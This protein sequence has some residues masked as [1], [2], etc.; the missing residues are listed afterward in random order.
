MTRIDISKV[1]PSVLSALR[2]RSQTDQTIS[3]LSPEE[4]FEQYCEWHGII[5]WADT[6]VKVLDNLR[7]ASVIPPVAE[8]TPA[9]TPAAENGM[10]GVQAAIAASAYARHEIG[11]DQSN[12]R[13]GQKLWD[14]EK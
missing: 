5:R 1:E 6:L 11:A 9:I 2:K 4:A 8:V 7:A 3:G 10:L 12:R 14:V 13:P